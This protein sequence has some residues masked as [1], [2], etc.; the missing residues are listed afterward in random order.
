MDKDLFNFDVSTAEPTVEENT[1]FL[2]E[3]VGEGKKFKDVS[4]LARGKYEADRYIE[5]LKLQT[6]KLQEE[7]NKR[8]GLE[9]LITK[10]NQNSQT[11][12]Q[13][14]TP[15]T[16]DMGSYNEVD[17]ESKVSEIINKMTLQKE[18]ETNMQKVERVLH[19]QFGDSAKLVLANTA[20]ENGLSPDEIKT[21]AQKSPKALLKLIGVSESPQPSSAPIAPR[22]QLTIGSGQGSVRNASYYEKLKNTD[23]KKYF[24]NEVTVQMMRDRAALGDAY[25][26]N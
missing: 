20:R 21:L 3:L 18:T 12:A 25:Y 24:S 14:N 17:L 9:E 15:A 23:P 5:S 1:D 16:P 2:T 8:A 6:T 26:K 13:I 22:G 10:I 19:E 4:A 11:P 7:L